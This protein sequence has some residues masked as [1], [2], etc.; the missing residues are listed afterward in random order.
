[1]F[2]RTAVATRS[3]HRLPSALSISEQLRPFRADLVDILSV[4]PW[5]LPIPKWGNYCGG[6]KHMEII[7]QWIECS[8]K[9]LYKLVLSLRMATRDS[10]AQNLKPYQFLQ[11][12]RVVFSSWA[13][14]VSN[15]STEQ[16]SLQA[17]FNWNGAEELFEM[18]PSPS[19]CP[20]ADQ[21]LYLRH[22]WQLFV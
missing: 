6:K 22:C 3:D 7:L 21:M 11:R 1:M 4:E 2:I 15:R 10:P 12:Q 8:E 19:T 13:G 18:P 14:T 9:A 20:R 5:H 16:P 17:I